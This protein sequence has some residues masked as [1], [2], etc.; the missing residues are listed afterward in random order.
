M[1]ETRILTPAERRERQ[2][3]TCQRVQEFL[4]VWPGVPSPQFQRLLARTE[5]RLAECRKRVAHYE[6]R[7]DSPAQ[8]RCLTFWRGR[9]ARAADYRDALTALT[10]E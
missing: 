1:T 4:S 7:P 10:Q 3:E 8:R 9:L 5:R 6:A 2:I